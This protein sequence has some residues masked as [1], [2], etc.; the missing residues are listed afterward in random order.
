MKRN[1][2]KTKELNK[3]S[4][5]YFKKNFNQLEGNENRRNRGRIF[6]NLSKNNS[7]FAVPETM[8]GNIEDRIKSLTEAEKKFLDD[9]L[10]MF[11]QGKKKD[12][13][14]IWQEIGSQKRGEFKVM[15]KDFN[16]RVAEYNQ[17]KRKGYVSLTDL[18]NILRPGL[19]PDDLR[20]IIKNSPRIDKLAPHLKKTLLRKTNLTNIPGGSRIFYKRPD[21][22]A[23]KKLKNYF[24]NQEYLNIAR[25]SE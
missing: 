23:M 2:Y 4:Q 16:N 11:Y 10:S 18:N 6:A 5:Y 7:K 14:Q 24:Q 17:L 19:D 12:L 25:Q 9:K 20:R 15:F 3:A 13:D 22:V 8:G 1:K 21:V